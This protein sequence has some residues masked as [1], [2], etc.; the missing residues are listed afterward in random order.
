MLFKTGLAGRKKMCRQLESDLS[1]RRSCLFYISKQQPLSAPSP[2]SIINS[3]RPP[4]KPHQ[5]KVV[6]FVLKIDP[7]KFFSSPFHEVQSLFR[8]KA[9]ERGGFTRARSKA[10]AHEARPKS[11]KLYENGQ[12]SSNNS[13]GSTFWI[14]DYCG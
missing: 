11:S 14:G 7:R 13:K 2:H 8:E 12:A 9:G 5:R 1:T 10:R 4:T 3:T 6:A